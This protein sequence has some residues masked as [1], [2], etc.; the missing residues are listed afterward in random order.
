[1]NIESLNLLI[2]ANH[3]DISL[4]G[5][6]HALQGLYMVPGNLLLEILGN[7]PVTANLFHIQASQ[8]TGYFSLNS[9]FSALFSLLFWLCVL[10]ELGNVKDHLKDWLRH[11]HPHRHSHLHW[12]GM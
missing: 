11:R 7:I 9:W 8:Q 6:W 3:D 10:V 4:A 2:N 5:A 12:P 1:M